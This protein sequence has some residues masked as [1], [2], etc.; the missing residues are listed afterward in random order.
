[1]HVFLLG[2]SHQ[3][4]PIDVRERL[5]F[6]S[7]DVGAAVETLAARYS[8]GEA[9]VLSTCNRS[10]I[11]VASDDPERARQE[12]IEFLGSYHELPAEAF[13]PHVFVRADE[14]ASRHLFRVAA[15]LDSLVVGE[16]QILGQVKD[17]FQVAA[18]AAVR[19]PGAHPPLPHLVRRRQARALGN[20]ARRRARFRWALPPWR[21]RARSSAVSTGAAC[22]WSAPARSAR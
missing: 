9:V 12:L 14:E 1:M 5:D 7:R 6:S 13:E 22:W 19:R 2:V 4:A 18:S 11:Y 21:W 3:T 15:G 10:E 16:P 17:A 8:A 20:G